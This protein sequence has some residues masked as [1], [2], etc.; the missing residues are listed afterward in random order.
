MKKLYDYLLEED[1]FTLKRLFL[2][3]LAGGLS[4][5]ICYTFL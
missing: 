3:F 2:V 5:L 4:A 1:K